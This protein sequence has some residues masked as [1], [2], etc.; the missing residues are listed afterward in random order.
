MSTSGENGAQWE[1]ILLGESW[2]EPWENKGEYRM[3]A[4]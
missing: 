1:G 2:N 3:G 4:G